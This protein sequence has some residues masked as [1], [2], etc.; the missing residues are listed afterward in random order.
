MTATTKLFDPAVSSATG[1]LWLVALNPAAFGSLAPVTIN[2]GQSATINVTIT[3]SGPSGTVI[4]GKLYVDTYVG[5]LPPY[6]A[7]TGDELA[8]IPYAYTVEWCVGWQRPPERDITLAA[9]K[10]ATRPVTASAAALIVGH[11][12]PGDPDLTFAKR[13]LV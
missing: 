9:T 13:G 10:S 2:P 12:R 7:T 11:D 5:Y 1:D 8:A 6:L 3:P 4:S